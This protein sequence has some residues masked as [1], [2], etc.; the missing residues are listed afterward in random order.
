MKEKDR[1]HLINRF[2]YLIIRVILAYFFKKRKQ[3]D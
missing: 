3:C 1:M 2:K